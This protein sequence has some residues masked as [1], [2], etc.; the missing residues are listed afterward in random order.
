[1]EL[2]FVGIDFTAAHLAGCAWDVLVGKLDLEIID[3]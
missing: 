1:M 3:T 2:Y